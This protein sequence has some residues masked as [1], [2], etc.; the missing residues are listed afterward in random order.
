VASFRSKAGLPGRCS[1]WRNISGEKA[2]RHVVI[3]QKIGQND[4][5]AMAA[6][7]REKT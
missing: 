2:G 5:A 4:F 7:T 1:S 6:I 3:H